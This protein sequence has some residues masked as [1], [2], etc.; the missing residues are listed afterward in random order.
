MFKT[1][2]Q[3]SWTSSLF[4]MFVFQVEV[5]NCQLELT[6]KSFAALAR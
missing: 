6:E 3:G 2:V 1:G 5:K 4:A